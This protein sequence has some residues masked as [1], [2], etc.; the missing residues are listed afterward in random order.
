ME[1]LVIDDKHKTA[2]IICDHIKMIP[3]VYCYPAYDIVNAQAHVDRHKVD[4]LV[5]DYD[6]NEKK[7]G[8]DFALYYKAINPKVKV[9]LY[10]GYTEDEIK[11]EDQLKIFKLKP[12]G[13]FYGHAID[14][15]MLK[16]KVISIKNSLA[17]DTI[18]ETKTDAT[19]S[20]AVNQYTELRVHDKEQDGRI[21]NV[22]R[23]VVEIKDTIKEEFKTF[24]AGLETV[25]LENKK[26]RSIQG[27]ISGSVGLVIAVIM[28][29]GMILR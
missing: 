21:N 2:D 12:D 8:I 25:R 15:K 11:D 19:I 29:M 26:G 14:C 16:Q 1:C 7:T 13:Y 9:I 18:K 23:Q 28:L 17:V 27:W 24:K 3:D 5:V 20:K 6:L 22:E 4:L 10:S